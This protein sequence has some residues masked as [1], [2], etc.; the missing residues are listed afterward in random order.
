MTLAQ[1]Y[2]TQFTTRQADRFVLFLA[3]AVVLHLG[4]IAVGVNLLQALLP[5]PKAEE[6]VVPIEFVYIDAPDPQSSPPPTQRRSVI[7]TTLDTAPEVT[8]QKPDAGKP[9]PL[10]PK[11]TTDPTPKP[12]SSGTRP[13][14]ATQPN[15][16]PVQ[17]TVPSVTPLPS[18][19]PKASSEPDPDKA[20]SAVPPAN[21][22]QTPTLPASP[23]PAA[24]NTLP[25]P[26]DESTALS[27]P[28]M[29][30]LPKP[31]TSPSP[32][33]SPS[34]LPEVTPSP[35]P[36]AE[37]GFDG[38]G[39]SG[40]PRASQSSP[41]TTSIAAAQDQVMGAYQQAINQRIEQYW[42]EV[43]V[44]VSRQA[45]VRFV[46]DREGNVI[47]V[48]LTESS[49]LAAADEAA[50]AAVRAATPFNPLPELYEAETLAIRF[51]FNYE[52]AQ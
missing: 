32:S 27:T 42:Q 7:N 30:P 31:E 16:K 51:T 21:N 37:S 24:P 25:K 20:P 29:A 50:I 2:R 1:K 5:E 45:K 48:E 3:T 46:V 49:G 40:T 8:A 6:D 15:R 34:E 19:A 9:S 13:I 28:Q 17:Q 23:P 33:L 36:A 18:A 52:V 4:A 14:N 26:P 35:A 38:T 47:Q 10:A 43:P 22:P 11:A 39:L 44:T 12:I 41:D